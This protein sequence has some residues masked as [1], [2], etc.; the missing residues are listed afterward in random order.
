MQQSPEYTDWYLQSP[1]LTKEEIRHPYR[2]LWLWLSCTVTGNFSHEL[3][4]VERGR[5]MSLYTRL[6][7]LID[8]VHVIHGLKKTQKKKKNA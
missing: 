1:K 5:I 8:A 6:E 3:N 2:V 7:K 4:R